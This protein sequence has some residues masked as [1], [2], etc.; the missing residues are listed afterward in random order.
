MGRR[1]HLSRRPLAGDQASELQKLQEKPVAAS[2]AGQCTNR[3]SIGIEIDGVVKVPRDM[4]V[5]AAVDRDASG[6]I[7]PCPA[8]GNRP[9]VRARGAELGHKDVRA[10][11]ARHH[12]GSGARV[13]VRRAV[14]N[15][16]GKDVTGRVQGKTHD[17]APSFNAAPDLLRPYQGACRVEL[18]DESGA[19]V[20]AGTA[21][22]EYPRGQNV[23][24]I[25]WLEVD[26]TVIGTTDNDIVGA[27]DEEVVALAVRRGRLAGKRA[28]PAVVAGRGQL[29]HETV[30]V[31]SGIDVLRASA[32]V[33]VHFPAKSSAHVDIAGGVGVNSVANGIGP[34]SA[35]DLLGPEWRATG[36]EFFDL[37]LGG[38][39]PCGV[40]VAGAVD[41]D[42]IDDLRVGGSPAVG[43]EHGPIRADLGD[44]PVLGGAAR[45]GERAETDRP[46]EIAAEIEVAA[47]V[48]RHRPS[49]TT[50]AGRAQHLIG[51]QQRA[52]G[53]IFGEV[54]VVRAA[55][56]EHVSVADVRGGAV[57]V[58]R[59]GKE[60][61]HDRV[62]RLV[63]GKVLRGDIDCGSPAER[64]RK[65]RPVLHPLEAESVYAATGPS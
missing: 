29:E 35:A 15:A 25:A 49:D 36:A 14:E 63:G 53:R 20:R 7:I 16:R 56:R 10:S 11:V 6:P 19:G 4:H 59:T 12:V 37:K 2:R 47:R 38:C 44:E 30:V 52:V 60:T 1:D 34:A 46:R 50:G 61:G 45:Q 54:D 23:R 64:S 41:G 43:P 33:E 13:E 51:P 39:T 57:E 58:H 62:S 27:V 22:W 18:G 9:L 26:G 21:R 31:S 55:G 32:W 48:G 42:S 17:A 24:S 65:H 28:D 3:V 40:H 8:D 5:S